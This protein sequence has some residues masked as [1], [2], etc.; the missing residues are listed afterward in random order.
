MGN[1]TKYFHEPHSWIMGHNGFQRFDDIVEAAS[2][3]IIKLIGKYWK[4]SMQTDSINW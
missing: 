2:L 4:S 3:T 1:W